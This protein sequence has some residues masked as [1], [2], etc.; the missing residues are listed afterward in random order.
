MKKEINFFVSPHYSGEVFEDKVS[1]MT[2]KKTD[3]ITVYNVRIE[4][5]KMAGLMEGFRKNFLF[6]YDR[7]THKMVNELR[8][9]VVKPEVNAPVVEDTPETI[10]LVEEEPAVEAP[11]AKEAPKKKQNN[12]KRQSKKVEETE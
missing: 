4:E 2:F 5:D 3:S 8:A 7:E 6:P 11:V 9:S 12:R 10:P 1:G